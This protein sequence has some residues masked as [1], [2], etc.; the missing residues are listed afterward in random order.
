MEEDPIIG[1]QSIADYLA[2]SLST[3]K[4][5][6]KEW[7]NKNFLIAK[8]IGRPPNRRKVVIAYPSILRRLHIL[9]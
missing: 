2:L 7:Q 3:V 9:S 6:S 8:K 5:H 4:K 1:L